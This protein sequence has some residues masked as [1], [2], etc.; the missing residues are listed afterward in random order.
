MLLQGGRK[1]K[2]LCL[3]LICF[4]SFAILQYCHCDISALSGMSRSVRAETGEGPRT[5]RSGTAARTDASRVSRGDTGSPAHAGAAGSSGPDAG[6]EQHAAMD[7]S[8]QQ[9]E[10]SL[11]YFA[12]TI[13][14]S[15]YLEKYGNEVL[16][17]TEYVI[18]AG[19]YAGAE[20][21]TVEMLK[22]YKGMEGMSVLTSDQA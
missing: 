6:Q 17:G 11:E 14:Y 16:P 18:D 15:E 13:K 3:V 19:S 12:D 5:D 9:Y 10:E 21:M 1:K 7:K 8:L 4:I 20:G 2:T 22:D